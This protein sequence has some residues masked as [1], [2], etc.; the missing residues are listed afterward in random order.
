MSKHKKKPQSSIRRCVLCGKTLSVEYGHCVVGATG[1][2]VCEECLLLSARIVDS[3]RLSPKAASETPPVILSP[4]EIIGRLDDAI[5]GQ[6]RAKQAVAVAL[7]KQQL[8]ASGDQSVPRSNLLLYGPTGC[9]KTA[10]VR[11][12]ANIVGLPF[13]SFDST[14]LTETGYRG[15]D[16]QDIVRD[17]ESRFKSH[18]NLPWSVVFLDEF[19]KLAAVGN[20][21]RMAYNQGTQHTLLK[22]V[23]GMEITCDNQLL[24]T[25]GFLFVFGGA[26]T[27]LTAPQEDPKPKRPV[28]FLVDPHGEDSSEE[29]L[30]DIHKIGVS[31]FI[32]FGMEP[33]LMG[34]VGQCVP[35]ESLSG[36]QLKRILLDSRLSVYRKYQ[37]FFRSQG[38]DLELSQSRMDDLIAQTVERGTGA[39]GLNALVEELVE[40]LLLRLA[41]GQ[42]QGRV[43]LGSE[44]RHVV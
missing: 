14:T 21:T 1:R 4:Q 40:P 30:R 24:S 10:L 38:V 2:V 23:E 18:P 41:E 13:I 36:P 12:A 32:D 3:Q 15:R 27:S 28:G 44:E 29:S 20:D 22:L 37:Y 9:G 33:E 16:A 26:F 7:W 6:S 8:R 19:D 31:A 43:I 17:L 42:L 5:I 34:R 39:R 35:L 11:E 25:E